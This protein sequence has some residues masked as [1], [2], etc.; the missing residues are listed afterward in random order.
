MYLIDTHTH[1]FLEEFDGDRMET[2]ARAEAAGVKQF[3]LPNI[4]T[5]SIDRLHNLCDIRPGVCFPMMG[6]H[7]T[8]VHKDFR[9]VLEEI[10]RRFELRHYIA[11]GETGIDLYWDTTFLKEQIEAFETQLRWSIE[12]DLPVAIHTRSAFPQVFESISRIGANNLRGVFHSFGGTLE[13]LKT[14]LGFPNFML[15]ING[16]VTFKNSQFGDYLSV[17]PLDRILLETDAPYLTPVPY[18]GK[19]NEPAFMVHT[20]QKIAE[21]YR[22]PLETVAAKT[23]GNACRMFGL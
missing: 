7:P 17:A 21:I 1:I 19:R 8:S 12:L 15:G 16:T 22:L 9:S 5:G 13:E 4:D 14:A 6:L 20:A 3:C 11:I 23:S 18:R 2:L 10:R